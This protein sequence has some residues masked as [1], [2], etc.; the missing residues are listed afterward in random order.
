[1]FSPIADALCKVVYITI[2]IIAGFQSSLALLRL[3]WDLKRIVT[4]I[5]ILEQV[6]S[7][8]VIRH[9]GRD[10]LG[11]AVPALHVVRG[12]PPQMTGVTVEG[13]AFTGM[14]VSNPDDFFIIQESKFLNNRGIFFLSESFRMIASV[15]ISHHKA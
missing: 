15:I 1:M 3:F 14:N 9:A 7:N 11:Q 2:E 13:S 10:R 8:V 6:L 5:V 12:S 4:I